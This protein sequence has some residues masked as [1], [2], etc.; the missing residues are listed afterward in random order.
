MLDKVGNSGSGLQV[1]WSVVISFFAV[2]PQ[3]VLLVLIG[4]TAHSLCLEL[5]Y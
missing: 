1:D 5:V 3:P 4:S 2:P